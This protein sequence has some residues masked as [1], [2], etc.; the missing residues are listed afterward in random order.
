[1]KFISASHGAPLDGS[2]CPS[3][4]LGPGAHRK[5]QTGGKI[6]MEVDVTASPDGVNLAPFDFFPTKDNRSI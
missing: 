2:R 5:M 4:A 1:M 3:S 6:D